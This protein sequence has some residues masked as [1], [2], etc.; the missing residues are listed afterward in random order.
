MFEPATDRLRR[1]S[2]RTCSFSNMLSRAG[3]SDTRRVTDDDGP[4]LSATPDDCD[5]GFAAVAA[6]VAAGELKDAAPAKP[7]APRTE[8][9]LGALIEE[10]ANSDCRR[11]R[12]AAAAAPVVVDAAPIMPLLAI[13]RPSALLLLFTDDDATDGFAVCVPQLRVS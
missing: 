3:A 2:L 4:N 8:V 5:N 12:L 10:D 11:R 6:V 9:G 13:D 1:V 7:L